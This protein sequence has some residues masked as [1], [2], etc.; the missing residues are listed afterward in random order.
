LAHEAVFVPTPELAEQAGMQQ[1]ALGLMREAAEHTSIEAVGKLAARA[2]VQT[3]VL[4]RLRPPPVY[5]I[6]IT[7]IVDDD[8]SGRIV[9]ASDG[10]EL[11]P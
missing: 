8:F 7:G 9:I 5:D 11:V 10:S 2:G 1:D 6:Q 3:L 4:V